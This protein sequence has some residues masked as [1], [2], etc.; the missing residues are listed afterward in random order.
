MDKVDLLEQRIDKHDQLL[1]KLA[2]NHQKMSKINLK[3]E[4]IEKLEDTH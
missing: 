2:D 1:E 3:Q 4:E